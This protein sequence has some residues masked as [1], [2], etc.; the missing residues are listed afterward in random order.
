MGG[1]SPRKSCP[2]KFLYK[3]PVDTITGAL[4][5]NQYCEIKSQSIYV[6]VHENVRINTRPNTWEISRVS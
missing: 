2:I 6:I 3:Q 4:N 1:N 5:E